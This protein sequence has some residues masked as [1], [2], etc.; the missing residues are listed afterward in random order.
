MKTSALTPSPLPQTKQDLS[1]A[2]Y[3]QRFVDERT[4]RFWI[5]QKFEQSIIEA[6][7]ALDPNASIEDLAKERKV[8]E[9]RIYS[10][11][12]AAIVREFRAQPEF[13]ELVRVLGN[14]PWVVKAEGKTG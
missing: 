3:T 6:Q 12:D 5:D 1:W 8:K 4:K 13:I 14:P 10:A 9:E 7:A 2:A 11:I